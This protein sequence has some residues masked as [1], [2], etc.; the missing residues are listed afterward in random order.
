VDDALQYQDKLALRV[1]LEREQLVDRIQR[2]VQEPEAKE[3]LVLQQISLLLALLPELIARKQDI[4]SSFEPVKQPPR[5]R[6]RR[7]FK[8]RR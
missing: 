8:S 6:S 5:Q 3:Q 7:L 4:E 2:L 1:N